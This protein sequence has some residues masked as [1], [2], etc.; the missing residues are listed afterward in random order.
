[1]IYNNL[2][3]IAE[4]YDC[5]LFDAYGVFWEGNGFYHNS[6]E[7]M[8]TLV[9]QNKK[10][11]ILSN[12][13]QLHK[14]AIQG[15]EKRGLFKNKHYTKLITSG[16]ILRKNLENGQLKF[17]SNNNPNKYYVIGMPH[18]EAFKDTKYQQVDNINEADFVYC[19]VPFIFKEDYNKYPQYKNMFL[20]VKKDENNDI[21]IW[22]SLT[23]KPFEEITNKIASLNLPALNANP[24]FTAKEG[25]PLMENSP[26]DFVIR[27]GSIA[28]LLR[29]KGCEVIEYGK[30]HQNIYDYTFEK[31]QQEN[32]HID[33]TRI[34]MIG[35]TIRTDIKGAINAQIS[36]ILCTETG[37]TAKS[38]SE[39]EKLETICKTENIDINQIIKIKSVGGK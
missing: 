35:D 1:M 14:T 22:D 28:E 7:T 21:Y 38:I 16:D 8:T 3:E 30:P 36:P 6:R 32:I 13:T 31:L 26:A 23:L 18:S 24:D 12:T 25:H 27:N 29:Q 20:P 34:C 39:G 10:V 4:N 37:V 2:L 19:G 33:K 5:F 17:K 11:I 15:Y 9:S